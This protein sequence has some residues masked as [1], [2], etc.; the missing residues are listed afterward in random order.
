MSGLD[1]DKDRARVARARP[2]NDNRWNSVATPRRPQAKGSPRRRSK[3]DWI[4][5]TNPS[6]EDFDHLRQCLRPLPSTVPEIAKRY[7]LM[8]EFPIQ[9]QTITRVLLEASSNG[10][11]RESYGEPPDKFLFALNRLTQ[12]KS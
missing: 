4:A 6:L 11:C 9:F 12:K 7:Q 10:L 8:Y 3:Q 5:L 1:W 2:F